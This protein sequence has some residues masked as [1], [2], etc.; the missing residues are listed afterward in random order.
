MDKNMSVLCTDHLNA[1]IRE[2]CVVK[3]REGE[4]DNNSEFRIPVEFC[5][6]IFIS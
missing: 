1:C 3:S 5:L 6:I 4:L 2:F